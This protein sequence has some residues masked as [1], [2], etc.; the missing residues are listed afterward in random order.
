MAKNR[1]DLKMPTFTK[2]RN[3]H[4][5]GTLHLFNELITPLELELFTEGSNCTPF[6]E[7]FIVTN[8]FFEHVL[9]TS[10]VVIGAF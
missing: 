2:K 1:P 6:W 8:N 9:I 5:L 3:E 10:T 7:D 4:L